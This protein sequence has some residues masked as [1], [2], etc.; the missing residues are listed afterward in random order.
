M[1]VSISERLLGVNVSVN[2]IV[3]MEEV[4]EIME[5]SLV[6]TY[7]CEDECR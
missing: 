2:K 1:R 4:C 3:R 6:K 7:V 5:G